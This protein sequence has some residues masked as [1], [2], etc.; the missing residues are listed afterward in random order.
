MQKDDWLSSV[1]AR[2][3]FTVLESDVN[4]IQA[5]D[6]REDAFY[7]CRIR[8]RANQKR[9]VLELGFRF[10]LSEVELVGDFWARPKLSSVVEIR[11]ANRLDQDRVCEIASESFRYDRFH[12]DAQIDQ[13]KANQIKER[14]VAAAFSCESEKDLWIAELRND[15]AGFC[16]TVRSP[17]IVRIDLIAVAA[18][19]TGNGIA[20]SLVASLP[21]CLKEERLTVLAG[22]Q[23][24]NVESLRLYDRIGMKKSQ[25]KDVYHR[26]YF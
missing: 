14:W 22:T 10:I 25:V 6:L 23:E 3:C 18:E 19:F 11:R 16:L 26:G 9:L 21:H 8:S 12:F 1:V 15:V 7:T 4:K 20:K 13:H 24:H 17:D 2:N 5:S